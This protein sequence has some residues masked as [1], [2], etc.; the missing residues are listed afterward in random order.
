MQKSDS[1]KELAAALA[2]AQGE[3]KAAQMNTT[4]KFLGNKYAD[5]GEVIKTAAPVLS[6]YSL[7]VSQPVEDNG[8]RVSVTTLLMHSSGEWME[9][10]I[11]MPVGEEKGKSRAQVIGSIITYLRRYGYASM[12]GVY[13]DEDNDGN[14][15]QTPKSAAQPKQESGKPAPEEPEKMS[16][17]TALEVT[18]SEGV[19][20][21]DL[22]G[23]ILSNMQIGINKAL[24]N[25]G[26]TAEQ[27]EQ[28]Q[29]KLAAI[30]TILKYRSTAHEG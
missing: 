5:L 24:K 22:N 19:K 12:V 26:L 27:R 1:I 16:L 20:Y 28:Y 18:N 4:N 10:T 7:S 23:E 15:K 9:A 11:S 2:K 25:N 8:E 3:L 17:K 13:A 21:G 29:F 30:Q 14:E 6:K